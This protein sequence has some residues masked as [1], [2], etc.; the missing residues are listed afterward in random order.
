MKMF[1][2]DLYKVFD[3]NGN[4][5][6]EQILGSTFG[7]KAHL[8]VDGEIYYHKEIG[9]FGGETHYNNKAGRLILKMDSVHQR[10]FYDG[11]K[12]T[13]IY[14]FKS[15][16]WYN[17]SISLYQFENDQL[18]VKFRRRYHFLKPIYEVQVEENFH[19]KLVILAFV[20]YYIKGYED[21]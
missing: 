16:S 18:L 9:F 19:N 20:F 1:K 12:Y 11:E 7:K 5:V 14:Y 15:K 10:I 13:E 8:K 21:A 17:S 2:A 3:E 4:L 6:G